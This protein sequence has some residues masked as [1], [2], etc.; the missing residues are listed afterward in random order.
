MSIIRVLTMFC[1]VNLG[2]TIAVS[3]SYATAQ[4]GDILIIDGE[5]QRIGT[6]PLEPL[7]EAHPEMRPKNEIMSTNLW[8]GY[9]ATWIISGDSLLLNDIKVLEP[10]SET[11]VYE[12]KYRSVMSDVFPDSTR[13]FAHWFTGHIIVP[14]GEVVEYVHMGYASVS[15]NYTILAIMEGVLK[16]TQR[17]TSEQFREFRMKQFRAYQ[18]TEEYRSELKE[19]ENDSENSDQD[20]LF[21]ETFLFDYLSGRYMSMIFDSEP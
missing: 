14:R 20:A 11:R 10:L 17:M 8:R 13:V 7:L 5:E 21:L 19:L 6:N 9:V 3:E 4:S 15:E 1:V 2:F 18:K 16:S 12:E